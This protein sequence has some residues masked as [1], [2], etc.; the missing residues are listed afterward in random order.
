MF[1]KRYNSIYERRRAEEAL[2]ESLQALRAYLD[3]SFGSCLPACTALQPFGR[4]SFPAVSASIPQKRLIPL[5]HECHSV[6]RHCTGCRF[7]IRAI[8]LW[9][10]YRIARAFVF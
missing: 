7:N 1:K 3:S 8:E 9:L 5:T 6:Y 4:V 10:S 2:G